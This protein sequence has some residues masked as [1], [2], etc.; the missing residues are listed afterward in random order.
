MAA[1]DPLHDLMIAAREGDD[2]SV[3]QLVR[4]TQPAVWRLCRSLGSTG[5]V[6]DLV[7]ETYMRA[8]RSLG[9]FRGESS[10]R[11]WLLA[12]AR[13][14]CADHVRSRIRDRRLLQRLESQH[15]SS[16]S[17]SSGEG[18]T[19]EL[20]E[21][22]HPDRREAF[23]LTQLLGLSYDEAAVVLEVPIG[24]VRSRVARARMD[25]RSS[26]TIAEAN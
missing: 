3:E 22:L 20:L 16:A 23:V 14:V 19:A 21:A 6:E 18:H 15:R 1:H 2:R 4:L 24:T 11:S 7:N 5:E 12:I 17:P 10:V 13:N 8:L 25:L 26:V 9:A